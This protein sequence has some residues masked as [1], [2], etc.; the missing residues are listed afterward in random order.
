MDVAVGVM[1]SQVEERT[2]VC[3]RLADMLSDAAAAVRAAAG[4]NGGSSSWWGAPLAQLTLGGMTATVGRA[5]V[6]LGAASA[7]YTGGQQQ[8][9]GG[10]VMGGWGVGGEGDRGVLMM[11]QGQGAGQALAAAAVSAVGA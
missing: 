4:S 9:H 8:Q 6:R 11:G 10:G 7:V 1:A 2:R 3:L 5:L